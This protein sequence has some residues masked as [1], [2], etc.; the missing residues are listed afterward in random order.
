MARGSKSEQGP[1]SKWYERGRPGSLIW[2]IE[3]SMK[4]LLVLAFCVSAVHAAEV[5]IAV[6]HPEGLVHGFLTLRNMQGELLANGDLI[7]NQ[8]GGRVTSQLIFHFKDGSLFDETVV[9]TQRGTFKLV[10]DRLVEKGSSFPNPVNMRINGR[11]GQVEVRYRQDDQEKTSSARVENASELANGLLL[12]LLK[13]LPPNSGETKFRYVVATPQPRV[14]TM[15]ASAEGDDRFTTGDELRKATSYRVKINIGGIT[16][17][18]ASFLGKTPPD[19]RVWI[20]GGDAPAF[21]KSEGQLAANGAVWRIELAS[22][23]WNGEK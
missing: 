18:L 21:V 23:T 4:F 11:S 8:H 16:G 12:V 9:F 20:L 1:C 13:N 3:I 14:V 17:V 7:Q 10:S 19:Q 5:P 2:R 22:P 15:I 6:R